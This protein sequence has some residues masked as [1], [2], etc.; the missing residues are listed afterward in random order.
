MYV[1]P[2]QERQEHQ[3]FDEVVGPLPLSKCSSQAKLLHV[4]PYGFR[5]VEC[6][7]LDNYRWENLPDCLPCT[8]NK[9]KQ[10]LKFLNC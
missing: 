5:P 2:R 1:S 7:A 9:V 6:A 10:I 4:G 3:L 8:W